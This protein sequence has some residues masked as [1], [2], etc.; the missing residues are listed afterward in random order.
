MA[1]ILVEQSLVIEAPAQR[2]YAIIADYHHGH[3]S[4]LPQKYFPKLEVLHGGVGAGTVIRFQL[5]AFG[6]IHTSTADITEPQPGRVLV[7]TVRETPTVTTFFVDP[8][9]EQSCKVTFHTAIDRPG[10]RGWIESFLV[11]GFLKKVYIEELE[12]LRRAA[13]DA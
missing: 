3:P 4:I 11:P 9:G 8:V 13:T 10:L 12:N 6:Q 2:V 7:E 1:R 5:K